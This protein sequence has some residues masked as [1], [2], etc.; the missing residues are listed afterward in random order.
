MNDSNLLQTLGQVSSSEASEVF[1]DRLRG[2]VRQMIKGIKGVRS[3]IE[4]NKRCQEPN[5]EFRRV[6]LAFFLV[7]VLVPGLASLRLLEPTCLF[8]RDILA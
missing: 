8:Q 6:S 1:R 5:W 7:A 2:L 4:R 3:Q